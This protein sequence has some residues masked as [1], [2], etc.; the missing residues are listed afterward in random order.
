MA[1]AK[2]TLDFIVI[3]AQ[4]AGTTTLFEYLRHH[5]EVSLPTGKEAPFFSRDQIYAR[6]WSAYMEN[7]SS[8]GGLL[9]PALKWGTVTPQYM[10]GGVLYTV[11]EAD[12]GGGNDERT[13]PTR[14]H[15]RL[16][17]VRLIAILRDPVERALSHHR[18]LVRRGDESR[19]FDEAIDALLD[20]EALAEAR[21]RPQDT[22]GYVTRGEYG[23]ILAGY[24]DVFARE[25]L[26]VV[27][28]DE[29]EHEPAQ[30]LRRIQ[31]F[32]GVS[33]EFEPPN[34]GERYLVAKPRRHFAWSDPG[35]WLGPSSPL[36][37]QGL[38]RAAR[39]SGAARALWHSFPLER[40]RRLRRP[41]ERLARKADRRNRLSGAGKQATAGAAPSESTLS[42]LREHYASEGARLAAI[43]GASP[44]WQAERNGKR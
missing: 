35:S 7:L 15:E 29:L 1:A 32:I 5:P 25:Q 27:F 36:S 11:G 43:L 16:P 39:R 13:V 23:R 41:Y 33:P 18:M 44:S 17:D 6:G 3:G 20:A 4:K 12:A 21:R 10:A 8:H 14:M 40:Q 28:T 2:D 34:L 31:A 42:R 9:D 37:P 26:L 22:T 38:Q 24:L 30:L 19:S